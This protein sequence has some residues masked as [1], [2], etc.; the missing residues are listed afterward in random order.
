MVLLAW[1]EVVETTRRDMCERVSERGVDTGNSWAEG[2]RT[3]GGYDS[4]STSISFSVG[5]RASL[6]SVRYCESW[7]AVGER[8]VDEVLAEECTLMRSGLSLII[9]GLIDAD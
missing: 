8:I 4:P 5:L 3:R 6:D 2:D 9:L 7:R 1:C